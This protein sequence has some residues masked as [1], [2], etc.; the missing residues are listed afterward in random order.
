LA[1]LRKMVSQQAQFIISTHSPILMAFPG[2]QIFQ[3]DG[4]KIHPAVYEDL[5]HVRLTR[6]FLNN[7]QS[8]LRRLEAEDEG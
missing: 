5:E 6:D 4:G 7:P 2:A 1:I 8:Y 3:L